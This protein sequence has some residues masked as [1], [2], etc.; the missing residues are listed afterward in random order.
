MADSP[1]ERIADRKGIKSETEYAIAI[2]AQVVGGV[3]WISRNPALA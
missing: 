2:A 1:K 3:Y